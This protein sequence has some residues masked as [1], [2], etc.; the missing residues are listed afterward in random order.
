MRGDHPAGAGHSRSTREGRALL[1]WQAA[2]NAV[3]GATP[4]LGAE[5]VPAGAAAG[6][7]LAE[8]VRADRDSPPFDRSAMD[9]YALRA[10]DAARP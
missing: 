9:G 4:V 5:V 6:R 8:E 3:L 1:S 7:V 2:L 10:G